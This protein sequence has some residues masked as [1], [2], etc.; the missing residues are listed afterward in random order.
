MLVDIAVNEIIIVAVTIKIT[1][2]NKVNLT[3]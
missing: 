3:A 2:P 1:N